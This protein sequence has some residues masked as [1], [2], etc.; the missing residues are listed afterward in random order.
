M[1]TLLLL[2]SL[3]FTLVKCIPLIDGSIGKVK[4][5]N[6][7]PQIAK[8]GDLPWIRERN[9]GNGT[10]LKLL[11]VDPS[12]HMFIAILR[13]EPGVVGQT[14][15]HYGNVYDYTLKGKYAFKEFEDK[16]ISEA[17]DLTTD[18]SGY[19]HTLYNPSDDEDCEILF[20]CYGA[21]EFLNDDGTTDFILDW[22]TFANRY[23]DYCM[24]K[25]NNIQC[26]D[27][28][29]NHNTNQHEI[30]TDSCN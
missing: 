12:K 11:H 15:R 6:P 14:H 20:W 21:L 30:E 4:L 24:D 28:I 18:D 17:G 3:I 29:A 2:L 16:Q 22:K 5:N 7:F 9:H 13:V 10:H 8:G 25:K 1:E 26:Y 23:Y 27:I 19:P